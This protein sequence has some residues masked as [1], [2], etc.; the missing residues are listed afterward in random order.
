M[1]KFLLLT[2][3]ILSLVACGKASDDI[4]IIFDVNAPVERTAV[5]AYHYNMVE[6]PLDD[7]GHGECAISGVEGTF[8]YVFYGMERKLIYLEKGDEAHITFDGNDF[9]GTFRFEGD[10]APAVEYLNTV[11]LTEF[12]EE[13]FALPF[14]EFKAMLAGMENEA[15]KLLE[16]R[17]LKGTGNFKKME[18]GRIRY[19]YASP[20]ITYPVGNRFVSPESEFVPSEEYYDAIREYFVEDEVFADVDQYREFMVEAAHIL[21]GE[22]RNLTGY[23]PKIV[24]EMRYIA[25]NCRNTKVRETLIHHLAAPYVDIYGVEDI[26]DLLNVYRTYVTD[27]VMTA[28]FQKKYDK[29]NRTKPGK[30]SPDFSASD[31]DGKVYSLKDFKGKYVYID[32]WATWC[33]PCRE[34]LPYMKGLVEEFGGKNIVFLGLSIDQNK[35]KWE[36]KVRSGELSGVQ[37]YLGTGSGF[38]ND[39]MIKGIPRFILL[40]RDG[41]VLNDN[42]SRPS[43][44]DTRRVLGALEGM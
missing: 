13:K 18:Q 19:S 12:S 27:P 30:P 11:S 15:Q 43:S 31:I 33:R 29:W 32:I 24:A 34:E 41:R 44:D 42:M 16:A 26:Q 23:Y 17:D 22:N 6:V 28:E 36:E 40:D 3:A 37:L 21:D 1:K 4:R 9:K 2:A 38:Q 14:G 5:V 35:A 39:Y 20:L 7:S 25:D 10:K 8:A